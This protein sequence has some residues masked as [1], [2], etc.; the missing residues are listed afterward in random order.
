[1][2]CVSLLFLYLGDYFVYLSLS[3][4]CRPDGAMSYHMFVV[5]F[6]F[7]YSILLLLLSILICLCSS[8]CCS[9]PCLFVFVS[10]F[11][12]SRVVPHCAPVR[13]VTITCGPEEGQVPMRD[14][15]R[16]GSEEGGAMLREVEKR[17]NVKKLFEIWQT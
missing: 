9:F 10:L 16:R 4:L 15:G 6:F 3:A 7:L 5:S 13:V 11:S 2:A 14:R 12:C 8:F 17:T 1:V